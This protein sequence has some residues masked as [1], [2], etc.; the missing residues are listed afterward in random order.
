MFDWRE[1]RTRIDWVLRLGLYTANKYKHASVFRERIS[2]LLQRLKS[3][4][5]RAPRRTRLLT[6]IS[7]LAFAL[8]FQIGR[9]EPERFPRVMTLAQRHA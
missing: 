5:W 8:D 2:E 9:G 7:V 6:E 4:F 3:A 1:P